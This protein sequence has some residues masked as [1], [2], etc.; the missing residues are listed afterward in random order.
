MGKNNGTVQNR[1]YF[2]CDTNHGIF[3]E[4]SKIIRIIAK[5]FKEFDNRIAI[6]DNVMTELY[7][8]GNV[9]FVGILGCTSS[10]NQKY[11][12]I[13]Y[14]ISLI[15]P[16]N[17]K[18][19]KLIQQNNNKLP[20]KRMSAVMLQHSNYY[21]H[22][23]TLSIDQSK[24]SSDYSWQSFDGKYENIAYFYCRKYQGVFSRQQQLILMEQQE[25]PRYI[26]PKS[27]CYK[28]KKKTTKKGKK[29]CNNIDITDSK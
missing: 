18:Q 12:G 22:L 10:I 21:N 20:K 25:K 17:A 9:K 15:T 27:V 5:K 28:K 14:G 7:G 24:Y 29:K 2:I 19:I 16:L 1:Q 8:P 13:W 4:R 6:C 26:P 23:Q 11:S 3:V